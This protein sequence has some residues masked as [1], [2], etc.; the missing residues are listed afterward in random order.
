MGICQKALSP[1][2]SPLH[3]VQKSVGIWRPCDDYRHL[4]LITEPD[5]YPLPN[6]ADL[7]S[8]LHEA[9]VF[10][11]LDLLKGYFLVPV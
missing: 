1:W 10:S 6:M 7:T 4:I 11:K 9:K 2:A 8:N 5:H 3:L